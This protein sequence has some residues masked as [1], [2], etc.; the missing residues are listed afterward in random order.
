VAK[1]SLNFY[2]YL[3]IVNDMDKPNTPN[4][5]NLCCALTPFVMCEVCNFRACIGCDNAQDNWTLKEHNPECPAD[6]SRWDSENY[7]VII[8]KDSEASQKTPTD[9]LTWAG[10][11]P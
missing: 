7:R 3:A 11:R 6:N 4:H 8:Y 2:V 1:T 10:K 9:V 5:N